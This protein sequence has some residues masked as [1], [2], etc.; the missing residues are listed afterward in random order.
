MVWGDGGPGEPFPTSQAEGG[1]VARPRQ[2]GRWAGSEWSWLLAL[3]SSILVIREATQLYRGTSHCLVV[4]WSII[5]F[6]LARVEKLRYC[7]ELE[8]E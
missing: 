2:A 4:L 7:S 3:S 6:F 8:D 1:C 5:F